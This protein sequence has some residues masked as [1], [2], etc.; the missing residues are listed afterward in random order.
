MVLELTWKQWSL[1]HVT[2][3]GRIDVW[4][5]VLGTKYGAWECTVVDSIE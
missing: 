3:I 5:L 4:G 2:Q 1:G